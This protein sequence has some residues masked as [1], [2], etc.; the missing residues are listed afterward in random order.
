MKKIVWYVFLFLPIQSLWAQ[1]DKIYKNLSEAL[2][3]PTQVYRLD[4]VEQKFSELPPEIGKLVNL[5]RLNMAR[6][7]L[8]RLPNEFSQL[9]NLQEL[10]LRGNRFTEIPLVIT[11]LP[12]LSKI[13]LDNNKFDSYPREFIAWV[14]DKDIELKFG[15][16]A[17]QVQ[18]EV[19]KYRKEKAENPENPDSEDKNTEIASEKSQEDSTKVSKNQDSVKTDENKSDDGGL[20]KR[21][22]RRKARQEER[23]K[24]RNKT[25]ESASKEDK[26]LIVKEMTEE[27]KDIKPFLEEEKKQLM[28]QNQAIRDRLQDIT[29]T[30][31]I[32]GEIKP[33]DRENLRNEILALEKQLAD[34]LESYQ[35][36]QAQALEDIAKIKKLAN[37]QE[38]FLVRN[39]QII[40]TLLIGILALVAIAFFFFRTASLRKKQRDELALKN[41]QINQQKEEIEA[42]RDQIEE[43]Q[44]KSEE[45]LLNI[46]PIEVAQELKAS[47]KATVKKYPSATVLFSDFAGFTGIA[48]QLPPE[49]LIEE[50]NECFSRF[51]EITE[52]YNLERIKT[53]GDAYMCVGG[54]PI[55]NQT[56][57]LDS[58]LA[59]LEMQDFIE[60]RRKT[61][62][63][64]GEAY[65]Q[66]RIGINSGE[67][68][69]GVIGKKKFAYDVWSDTVN[70]ASRM[71]SGSEE[72]KV[73]ISA[74]TFNL[75]KDFFVCEYRGKLKA[76][77]KGEMDMYF[78]KSIVP[79]L[80]IDNQ[81]LEP[82]EKFW[83]LKKEK[84]GV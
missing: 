25:K 56:N 5:Q 3:N 69:A 80:S 11:K 12:K 19:K 31:N 74:N 62:Q 10:S 32:E 66:C 45:L 26:T 54:V 47:G 52:K 79:E 6:N 75:V 73:N 84:F 16:M 21:E 76:K 78:V 24:R 61:K 30:L 34:N 71:E 9:T 17:L 46:L 2:A 22:E 8:N 39:R 58:I 57:P 49:K 65:W 60:E 48:G 72:G 55:A 43:E 59:G 36:L 27:I 64:K 40:W 41:E 1:P 82:N 23:E 29:E 14:A 83:E 4:L 38:A 81:G 51:D 13:D 20:T 53:I 35:K 44:K 67:V 7:N 63:A 33:E 18:K 15:A 68:I 28:E 70:I 50:L 77:G 42:Q 37:I